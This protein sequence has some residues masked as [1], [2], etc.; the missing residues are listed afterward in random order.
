MFL[1]GFWKLY[2]L[3]ASMRGRGGGVPMGILWNCN[4]IGGVTSFPIYFLF[5]KSDSL[6]ST[7]KKSVLLLKTLLKW[8]LIGF[9]IAN[10]CK[11]RAKRREMGQIRSKRFL[12][13][14]YLSKAHK[15]LEAKL[16]AKFGVWAFWAAITLS[17]HSKW[18]NTTYWWNFNKYTWHSVRRGIIYL[19]NNGILPIARSAYLLW[20]RAYS[21]FIL[22]DGNRWDFSVNFYA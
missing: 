5:S 1:F 11:H 2:T 9:C 8:C 21:V 7:M 17:A 18:L 13:E 12:M 16:R 4:Q 6:I 20:E 22:S 14:K 10:T 15:P 3:P 19:R